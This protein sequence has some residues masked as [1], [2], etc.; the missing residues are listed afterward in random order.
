MI[1]RCT[2]RLLKLLGPAE[3]HASEANDEDWYANLVWLDK[4]K[5]VLLMHAG[6]LFPI[7]VPDVRATDLRPF[8]PFVTP[9]IREA[10]VS[11]GLPSDLFGPLVPGDV[12]V[13]KTASRSLVASMNDMVA[14][15]RHR[16]RYF[17][18]LRPSDAP[19]LNSELRDTP[20]GARDYRTPRELALER[21]ARNDR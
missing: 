8:G 16:L 11:E 18:Y 9:Y 13:A 4:R 7:Y 10:L 20:Y 12:R 5:W 21:A 17:G 2:A 3:L 15:A 6:T 14:Q 1:L 19:A